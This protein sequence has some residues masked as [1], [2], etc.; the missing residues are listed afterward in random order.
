MS[1]YHGIMNVFFIIQSSLS[2]GRLQDAELEKLNRI[3]TMSA[4]MIDLK[5]KHS[6]LM[7]EIVRLMKKKDEIEKNRKMQKYKEQNQ[8]LDEKER[9]LCRKTNQLLQELASCSDESPFNK[10]LIN[11]L[12]NMKGK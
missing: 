11:L 2:P 3:S 7:E 12:G 1:E 9:E 4:S 10:A 8:K 6:S 5:K